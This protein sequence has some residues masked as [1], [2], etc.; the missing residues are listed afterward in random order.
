[1]SK[2]EEMQYDKKITP[3]LHSLRWSSIELRIC[4]LVC[5]A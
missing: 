5:R 1:M 3:E 2:E 4:V